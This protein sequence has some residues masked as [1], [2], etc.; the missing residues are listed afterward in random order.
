VAGDRAGRVGRA[1]QTSARCFQL[2]TGQGQGKGG[3]R[4]ARA[5]SRPLFSVTLAFTDKSSDDIVQ[6]IIVFTNCH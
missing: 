3:A 6:I 2:Q 4:V 1:G 5:D